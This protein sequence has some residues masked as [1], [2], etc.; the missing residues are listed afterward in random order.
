MT[1]SIFSAGTKTVVNAEGAATNV[2]TTTASDTGATIEKVID[3]TTVNPDNGK[4]YDGIVF[5]VS[6]TNYSFSKQI[7][8]KSS[9]T[10]T[11]AE[12]VSVVVDQG[13][14]CMSGVTL[15]FNGRDRSQLMEKIKLPVKVLGQ[16]M[17]Q[18]TYILFLTIRM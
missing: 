15:T 13:I 16:Y 4:A 7:Q 11:T 18:M 8:L 17:E 1:L 10:I 3:G 12:N 14:H 6:N 5:A 9:F 2:Y